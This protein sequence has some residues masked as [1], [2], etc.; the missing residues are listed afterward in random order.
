MKPINASQLHEIL[1]RRPSTPVIDVLPVETHR[2]AHIPGT[3]NVPLDDPAFFDKVQRLAADK[4]QPVAVYCARRECDASSRAAAALEEAG[5]RNVYDFE[6]GMAEWEAAG[7][8][9][10][11]T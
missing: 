8:S 5:Y 4:D 2:R 11:A 1:L 7:Y 9:L 10:V 6:G 3:A